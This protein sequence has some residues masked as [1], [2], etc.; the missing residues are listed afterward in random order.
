MSL[1]AVASTLIWDICRPYGPD[2]TGPVPWLGTLH[3]KWIVFLGPNEFNGLD[4]DRL[5]ADGGSQHGT[6][7][8]RGARPTANP[9]VYA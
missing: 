9:L 5:N 8:V 1:R 7:R 2:R 3:L 6:L 4:A